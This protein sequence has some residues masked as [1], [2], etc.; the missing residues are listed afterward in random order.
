MAFWLVWQAIVAALVMANPGRLPSEWQAVSVLSDEEQNPS[1]DVEGAPA[2]GRKR[3]LSGRT[4]VPHELRSKLKKMTFKLCP[5]AKN[6]RGNRRSCFHQF[7]SQVD[8]LY[9]L[10]S[11]L[12]VLDKQDFD[13]RAAQFHWSI[14]NLVYLW[15]HRF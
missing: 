1:P 5:C 7:Q 4:L 6:K 2:S 8:R 12:D 3:R 10:R 13:D 14:F 15:V 9:Q 11:Q